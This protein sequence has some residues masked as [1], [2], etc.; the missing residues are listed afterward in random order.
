MQTRKVENLSK[1]VREFSE[2]NDSFEDSIATRLAKIQAEANF[3]DGESTALVMVRRINS[4]RF[5]MQG[6]RN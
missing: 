2:M 3:V 4:P 1:T 6:G 5:K